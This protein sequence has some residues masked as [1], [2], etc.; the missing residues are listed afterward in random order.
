M[1]KV[2][3]TKE[4]KKR[5]MAYQP[6]VFAVSGIKNS[7]K[8]TLIEKLVTALT[9]K[10]Y[11]VGV[12]KHD[13]H[14]FVA[15]HEGTDS[16]RHKKAGAKNVIVYSKTKMMMIEETQ[17]PCIDTLLEYQ[18][19]MDVVIL[20]GMKYSKFPKIEIVRSA[21]SKENVCDPRTLIALVTDT[22]LQLKDVKKINLNDFD[23]ILECVMAYI[24]AQQ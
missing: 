1:V 5:K 6:I 9:H 3:T 7:G 14:E 4:I 24:R 13:G 21:I 16:F 20:E 22:S 15:D 23:A 18:K 2:V 8:T 17:E 12:V 10:G 11:D 19:H